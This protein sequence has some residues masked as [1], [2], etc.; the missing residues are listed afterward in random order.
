[1]KSCHKLFIGAALS[2]IGFIFIGYALIYDIKPDSFHGL[3]AGL[4]L[5]IGMPMYF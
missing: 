1:M 5:T 4:L 3:I 2:I